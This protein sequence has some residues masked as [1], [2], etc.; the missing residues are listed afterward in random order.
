MRVIFAGGGTGGHLYPG[1]AI[2]RAMVK[3]D[4]RIEPFFVGAERGIE[5]EV[6]PQ[7]GF[8]FELL[9]LHPLYR[10]R[11]WE[12]WKTLRGMA[13]A[14]NSIH[15][16]VESEAPACVVGT[17]G[18][19]AGLALGYAAYHAIPIVLQEQNTYP[20]LTVRFFSRY[21]AQV[22]L[23]FPEARTRLWAS[24]RTKV[25]DSGNPIE[26]PPADAFDKGPAR[27]K[28]GF[29]TAGKVLLVYGGSQGSQAINDA[30]AGWVR[31]GLPNDLS[32]IWATGRANYEKFASLEN[33]QVKVR[34]Y[35]APISEAYRAADLA[36]SRAGAMATAELCAWGIPA[37]VVP[38]P[39]AAADHQTANA[40]ALES[41]GAARVIRQADLSSETLST[42]LDGLLQDPGVLK[43]MRQKALERARPTAAS[44]IARHILSLIDL[45]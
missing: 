18:Y 37:V 17:G 14:W 9:D 29:K 2:A 12:N 5:R 40:K 45:K 15:A 35:I 22:H 33:D 21:A 3:A 43:S 16:E 7:V 39:T 34:A 32:V 41:A 25:F 24:K 6:L 38:L 23:G 30:V 31:S 36:L 26:P 20:G 27:Q 42:T 13:T 8:P 19:A 4:S 11:P 28:W 44:D 10:S 1:L